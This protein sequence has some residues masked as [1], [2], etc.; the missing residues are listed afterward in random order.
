MKNCPQCGA[1]AEDDA[2]FCQQCGA[3]LQ[4]GAPAAE[5]YQQS[6]QTY[7]QA[8]QQGYQPAYQPP[9]QGYQQ[10]YQQ[11]YQPCSYQNAQPAYP[12]AVSQDVADA[13]SKA[14][15]AMVCGIIGLVTSLGIIFGIIAIV[16]GRRAKET[17]SRAG[18]PCGQATA[19]I[20][21]GIIG[22]VESI[23]VIICVILF[24]ALIAAMASS[25]YY[26]LLPVATGFLHAFI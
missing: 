13:E 19:G 4:S 14:T 12:G 21:C 20:V 1:G 7:S 10:P 8:P 22:L 11:P 23:L 3:S 25:Y 6:Q 16:M 26:Y 15:G 17:L 24:I 18:R 2:A 9:Q 5:P